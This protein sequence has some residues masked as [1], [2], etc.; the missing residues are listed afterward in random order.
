MARTAITPVKLTRD[1]PSNAVLV[2]TAPTTAADGFTIDV[3]AVKDHNLLL[4]FTNTN[5]STTARS[6]T[7]KM[8]NGLQ[9]VADLASGDIAAGAT[10]AIVISSGKFENV[11]GDDKGLIRII[12]S[13]AELKIAAIIMP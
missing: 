12:P 2:M 4:V 9:G 13:H 6:Y 10:G 3:S 5:A 8:G 7:V 1:T 11:S